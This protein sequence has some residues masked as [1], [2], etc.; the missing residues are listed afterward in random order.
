M[1]TSKLR[2][3]GCNILGHDVWKM[4]FESEWVK[5]QWVFNGGGINQLFCYVKDIQLS[6]HF[7]TSCM[8]MSTLNCS[9]REPSGFAMSQVSMGVYRVT[10]P[11]A[12]VYTFEFTATDNHRLSAKARIAVVVRQGTN[13]IMCHIAVMCWIHFVWYVD[14]VNNTNSTKYTLAKWS[15]VE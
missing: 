7:S 15:S 4:K 2:L 12:G 1:W 13:I 9:P 5:E 14:L 11:K 3:S 6:N 8:F 10:Y